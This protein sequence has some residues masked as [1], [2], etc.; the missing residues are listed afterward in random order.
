MLVK[1]WDHYGLDEDGDKVA[2]GEF[3]PPPPPANDPQF[4]TCTAAK[5]A[6][7][8]PYFRGVDPE[9]AWYN[10]ADDDGIVCE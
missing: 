9:Y 7:Y 2:C 4:A 5:N 3:L 8:G 10:D 6:G 1:G